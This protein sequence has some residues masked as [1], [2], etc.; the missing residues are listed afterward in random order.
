MVDVIPIS[1]VLILSQL[2][3]N[4]IGV[5]YVGPSNLIMELVRSMPLYSMVMPYF[6]IIIIEASFI[7]TIIHTIDGVRSRPQTPRG[8]KFVRLHEDIPREVNKVFL[9][10]H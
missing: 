10:N 3:Q 8:T 6:I 9:V 1:V 7:L 5:T 4:N 2:H